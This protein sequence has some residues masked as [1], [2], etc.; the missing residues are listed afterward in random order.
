[1]S[2]KLRVGFVIDGRVPSLASV[3][4]QKIR[5]W[6]WLFGCRT[7]S[8]VGLMRFGWIAR[9][10]AAQGASYSSYHPL[11]RYDAVI[12]L[13]S[14][15]DESRLLAQE[16][17]AKD[18]RVIFDVNVDYFT[19]SEGTFYYR[20][21]APSAEQQRQALAMAA[22]SDA[23]IADSSHIA[24]T[25]AGHHACIRW[26]S[27]NVD[28]RQ[29]PPRRAWARTGKLDLLWSGE[30]V[31]LF[32]LLSIDDVLREFARHVRLTLVT[33]SLAALDRWVPPWRARF[34]S[35]LGTIDHR[36]VPW[37]SISSLLDLYS[38]GGVFISPRFLDNT[39]N[40]GHTE[41]KIALPMAC[42]RVALGSPLPSYLDV[43]GR[44]SGHGLRICY[45]TTQWRE[46][47][48]A[49]LSD[50]F[51]FAGEENAAHEVIARHY[52]TPVVAAA[53]RQFVEEIC[54]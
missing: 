51:D 52:S 27:D 40:L 17:R 11:R 53:H 3:A 4:Q 16:L 50:R 45:D 12:F 15:S 2:R 48:D 39:Y 38:H 28:L 9:E 1:M 22:L 18:T 49:I 34:E 32:E 43:A 14:M 8:S 54:G 47:F 31:K 41:W 44:S 7:S 36:I 33:G 46:T 25:C 35:L 24:R 20:E 21:M 5:P 10:L 13:K 29:A 19:P 23:L 6:E 26:I 42:G 30:A 37:K